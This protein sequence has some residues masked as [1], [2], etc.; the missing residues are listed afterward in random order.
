MVA[1]LRVTQ[2]VGELNRQPPPNCAIRLKSHHM[3]VGSYITTL[4][5]SYQVFISSPS[6]TFG[7]IRLCYPLRFFSLFHLPSLFVF[8]FVS[9][10]DVV[11]WV[12]PIFYN[13]N[14]KAV[15]F[16]MLNRHS[17]TVYTTPV[18][19]LPGLLSRAGDRTDMQRF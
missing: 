9:R 13:D 15:P 1:V 19:P 5:R 7:I 11:F 2:K 3:L 16:P 4:Y 8:L 12:D 6:Y 14:N 18:P 10:I 17:T